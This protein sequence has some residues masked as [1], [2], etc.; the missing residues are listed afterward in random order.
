LQVPVEH[1]ADA[2]Q[3]LPIAEH[4]PLLIAGENLDA[5]TGVGVDVHIRQGQEFV[6]ENA[7][8]MMMNANMKPKK[9]SKT[10]SYIMN[11]LLLLEQN[12]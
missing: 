9:A 6:R 8:A 7:R 4:L 2:H 3:C 11:I 12:I 1:V 10:L 5:A